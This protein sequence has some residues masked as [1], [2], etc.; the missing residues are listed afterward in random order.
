MMEHGKIPQQASHKK[1]NP[2][3]L[4]HAQDRMELP[5]TLVPWNAPFYLACVNSYGAAGS[6]AAALIRQGPS[7]KAKQS[8]GIAKDV[9]GTRYPFFVSATSASSVIS[10][11][12]T[13][14]TW[15]GKAGPGVQVS[16]L[17]FN[18]ADRAN[19][20]LS[21]TFS[22]TVGTIFEL[23]EKLTG[24]N[25]GTITVTPNPESVVLVFGGQESLFVGLSNQ[26]YQ[27]SKLLRGHL[28][29]CNEILISLGFESLYPAI[30]QLTRVSNLKTLHAA[31]F[32]IQYA[33]AKAWIDSGLKVSAVVGHSFGQ[34]TALCISG[35][36]SL[37][38]ALKLACGRA[39]IIAQHWGPE[40]GSMLSINADRK[41]VLKALDSVR[42]NL[43]I[44]CYNGPTRHVVVGSESE[45]DALED[46]L[47]ENPSFGSS[48][49][50]TRL[51]VTHGYHSRFTDPLLPHLT[52]FSKAL[53]WKE[54]TVHL[55]LCTESAEEPDH[56]LVA[57]HARRSVFFHQAIQRLEQ[58]FPK[59]TFLEAGRGSSVIQLVKGSVTRSAD[60]LF[61]SPQLTTS[62]ALN[63]LADN[64][65]QLWKAGYA[66]QYWPYHRV[67]RAQYQFLRVPSYQFEQTRHWLGFT[68]GRGEKEVV[69]EPVIIEKATPPPNKLM[70]FLE[71]KD[72]KKSEAVFWISPRSDR[73]KS[74]LKGHV[75]AGQ[76]LAPASLYFEI[77]ARAALFL[78]QDIPA[79]TWRPV[80]QDLAMN[81]PIG[82]DES[83]TILLTLKRFDDTTPAWSFSITTQLPPSPSGRVS[84]PFEHSTGRVFLQR[85]DDPV[86]AQTFRRFET[87]TGARRCEEIMNHPDSEGM[88]GKHIYRAFNHIVHYAENF[89]GIKKVACLRLEAA[90]KVTM[91]VDPSD[92]VDQRLCDTPMTDSFMQFGGFLVNYFNNDSL[93]DVLVCSK[94]GQIEIGADFDPDAKEWLV[95]ANM[96]EGGTSDATSDAYVFEASSKKMVMAAFGFQFHK[97]SQTLLARMLKSAN[98]SASSSE[99]SDKPAA[100]PKVQKDPVEQPT[101]KAQLA[102]APKR[103][104]AAP[105]QPSKRSEVLQVLHNITDIPL[106]ELK[107]ESTLDDLGVDSLMATEVLN[108]IRAS[109]GLTIDLA[110]FL[111]FPD[112]KA[113]FIYVDSQLGG[114]SVEEETEE[115]DIPA[116][117]HQ[118]VSALPALPPQPTQVK[119]EQPAKFSRR[120]E[121]LQV[122]HNV[123]DIPLEDLKDKST[124]DDLGIDSLMATEVLNDIRLELGLTI[125]LVTFLDFPDIGAIAA[126]IDSFGDDGTEDSS[127]TEGVILTP[128]A[129]PV[130]TSA[131]TSELLVSAGQQLSNSREPQSRPSIQSAY[132]SFKQIEF[133]YDQLAEGTKAANFWAGAYPEQKR[134]VLAYV[135]EAYAKL[136]CDL[137]R[138]SHG[139]AVPEVQALP[140]FKQLVRQYYRVLE[141]GDLIVSTNGRFIR[142]DVKVDPTPAEDI[143]QAMRGRWPQHDNVNELV[144]V[145]GVD[146]AECLIGKKDG[147]Q[148]IFGNRAT[149]AL[150][151]DMYANWPLLRTPTILLGDFLESA[152]NNSTGSGK[153]RIL[154]IGAGTGGTTRHLVKYLQ[155]HGIPFEYTFTDI[156][157]SLVGAAKKTFKGIEEMSF[158]VLDIEK[159]PSQDYLNAFHVIIATNCIH[160]TRNLNQS[161]GT[162]H[163]MLRPDGALA[164][165][166]ITQ[167]MF[168]LDIVVGLFE[169]W[170]LFEDNRTHALVNEKHWEREMK[171]VGFKE[172]LWTD[173]KSPESKT[174]RVIGAFKTAPVAAKKPA[175]K[176]SMETVVYKT[177]GDTDIQADVYYPIDPPKTKLPVGKHAH[178][179]ALSAKY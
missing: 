48:I 137:K 90:G 61:L 151:E 138:L 111:S 136:G 134:L 14:S 178:G 155:S 132:D 66:V 27:S 162:L 169:G 176:M 38:D 43:E 166:E 116:Q 40:P 104:P 47:A 37:T 20:S 57:S 17:A 73:F 29:A 161:L 168:W 45:V 154:E 2:K 80:V 117:Q 157:S 99:K 146:L 141:D 102:A 143:Y 165:I 12:Q 21:H 9:A 63:S 5:R 88:D 44:A 170:W 81:S 25:T 33:S 15:L 83:R 128:A 152:F 51:Q 11:C 107:D 129:P 50:R 92:P 174:V 172:V 74:M 89:R 98:K 68:S 130:P 76:S 167:N 1:F 105:R 72:A 24:L 142:T 79:I 32:A 54:P 127:S 173:G 46:F 59:A 177:L 52:A 53:D 96:T 97:M 135:V 147:L 35:V 112:L 124:L 139:D 28:D 30:F 103:A 26:V 133:E 101:A 91:V 19:H 108:D 56:H 93:E 100:R 179:S 123:T 49:R 85:R 110:T 34:I 121:L 106:Q 86:A 95:Y 120:G 69:P 140:R 171:G 70:T 144:R 158:E 150:L 8:N 55:E 125:D 3:I 122:L 87:L 58:K 109:L 153:F 42:G 163:K 131:P 23:K 39:S 84:A 145:I 78:Q 75:M 65:V 71:F 4:T 16:D 22:T 13:L 148:L 10:Y 175:T 36:L 164:L 119:R 149:K 156:S 82:L 31:L 114:T 94:I 118:P 18:L 41:T 6:N 159:P 113:I 115:F 62:D 77:A 7:S 64:T 160:A 67:Q 126:Y 60:H